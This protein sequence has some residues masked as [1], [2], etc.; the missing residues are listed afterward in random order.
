M[1]FFLHLRDVWRRPC[2]PVEP[3]T[4][5]R[6]PPW[7]NPARTTF[8]GLSLDL[9]GY[10]GLTGDPYRSD[11]AARSSSAGLL[12]PKRCQHI[13]NSTGDE[14]K[15][16]PY[17]VMWRSTKLCQPCTFDM[18]MKMFN[19][20]N[21]S[22][23][24][25]MIENCKKNSVDSISIVQKSSIEKPINDIIIPC[26]TLPNCDVV[27]QETSRPFLAEI[28]DLKSPNKSIEATSS[29][30]TLG[31]GATKQR[32][33]CRLRCDRSDRCSDRFDRCPYWSNWGGNP[34]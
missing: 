22:G 17:G 4:T 24:F 28:V 16:K 13:G 12:A 18:I 26:K 21:L 5:L 31:G 1:L 8:V 2:W 33:R 3:R 6:A 32:H 25:S 14:I 19:L 15:F 23:A 34:V 9:P 7:R 27:G 10:T 29:T 30:S 20:C 11:R